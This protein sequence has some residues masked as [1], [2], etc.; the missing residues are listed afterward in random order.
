M[1]PFFIG[2]HIMGFFSWKTADSKESIANIHSTHQNARKPVYLLQPNKD[3]I[4]ETAY[5]G[6]GVFGGVDAYAW[7]AKMNIQTDEVKKLDLYEDSSEL[8]SKGI[9]LFYENRESITFHLKFSFNPNANY[10]ELGASEDCEFQGFFY[11]N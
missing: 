4:C 1:Y 9:D 3:P 10:S 2:V 8:R 7:L 5:D 11:D 6:Y